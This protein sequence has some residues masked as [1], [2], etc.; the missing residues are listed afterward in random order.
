MSHYNELFMSIMTSIMSNSYIFGVLQL[1]E[2]FCQSVI[3]YFNSYLS[4]KYT[5]LVE[6][7]PVHFIHL[8]FYEVYCATYGQSYDLNFFSHLFIPFQL[9]SD[10]KYRKFILVLQQNSKEIYDINSLI[11][12]MDNMSIIV[13]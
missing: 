3:E 8:A 13:N 10:T 12:R 6:M 7:Y 5:Y 9:Q 2:N 1:P 11:T 4:S